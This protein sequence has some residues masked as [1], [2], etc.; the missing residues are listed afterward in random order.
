MTRLI[1]ALVLAV[2]ILAVL[3]FTSSTIFLCV[4]LLLVFRAGWE[5]QTLVNLCGWRV[6]AWEGAL[7]A[8]AFVL[9]LWVGGVLPVLVL[10]VI[11]LRVFL[12]AFSYQAFRE[13]LSL[14]AVSFLG[15]IWVGG[16]GGFIALIRTFPGGM[17]AIFF[18]FVIVWANDIA[19][20]F[21]GKTLGK[22]KLAPKI[23]PGKTL[24]GAIGGILAGVL[25]GVL[26]TLCMDVPGVDPW[27]AIPVSVCIGLFALIGDLGESILKRAAGEKDASDIIPG[28]GGLLDRIDGLLM[29]GPAFYG[30]LYWVRF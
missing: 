8:C 6:R 11:L 18:L 21:T 4:V 5:F 29:A 23:S 3:F 10:A 20:M 30:Y 13:S 16:A 19:A 7:D 14:T 27:L 25:V 22:R 1:S 12:K 15:V 28:H 26:T 9:A 2:P 24:E 17:E